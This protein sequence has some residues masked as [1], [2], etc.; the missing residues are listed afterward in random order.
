M[1]TATQVLLRDYFGILNVNLQM[2]YMPMKARHFHNDAFH[3][4]LLIIYPILITVFTSIGVKLLSLTEE[5]NEKEI[6]AV[7][8]NIGTRPL[9]QWTVKSMVELAFGIII[10][11]LVAYFGVTYIITYTSFVFLWYF[12]VIYIIEVFLLSEVINL[13]FE[14][15]TAEYVEIILEIVGVLIQVQSLFATRIHPWFVYSTSILPYM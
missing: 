1:T 7:L 10:S 11:P 5:S 9:P 12:T 2:L 13:L 4:S 14:E 3:E 15:E 6:S 8:N